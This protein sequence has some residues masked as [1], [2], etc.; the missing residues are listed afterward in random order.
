MNRLVGKTE[1]FVTFFFF[2]IL[3]EQPCVYKY[4]LFN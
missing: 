4:V 2:F 3:F 1:V